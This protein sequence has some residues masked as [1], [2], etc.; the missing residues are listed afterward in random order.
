MTSDGMPNVLLAIYR[1]LVAERSAPRQKIVQVCA[2]SIVCRQDRASSTLNTWLK[3]GL[4]T[5]GE[6]VIRLAPDAPRDESR[7]RTWLRSLIFRAE[8]N[9]PFW[10]SE[11]VRSADFTRGL[12]WCLALD[13]FR[14][15]GHGFKDVDALELDSLPREVEVFRNDTRWNGFKAWA[16]FL[17]FAWQAR[18]PKKYTLVV[19]PTPAIRDVLPT[20]FGASTE[21]TQKDF[22]DRVRQPLPILDGGT[23]RL[24]VEE[25]LRPGHW[26]QPQPDELSI[27][28]SLAL[29]RLHVEGI[30]DFKDRADPIAGR[31]N[32]VGRNGRRLAGVS[33]V[34]FKGVLA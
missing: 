10:G 30:I 8:N 21:L 32:L 33:H 1:Y 29:R 13:P 14:L 23:Y 15:H 11:G 20:V 12:A 22:L 28:L 5:D 9:E 25:E 24:L 19:D 17:G 3:L 34:V 26:P 7:L 18:Y 31:V 16:L 6:G 27:S 2:P 4:F